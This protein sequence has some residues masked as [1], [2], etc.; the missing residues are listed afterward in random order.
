MNNKLTIGQLSKKVDLPTK[1]IRFYEESG[2]IGK[3]QRS[4]NGYRVYE[5]STIKELQLLK[6]ARD[7]GLPISEI[8]RLMIGCKEGK[9]CHHSQQYI[10]SGID[11]YMTVLDEKISHLATL[12]QKLSDLRHQLPLQK[13]QKDAYCCNILH[14]LS[15]DEKG[16]EIK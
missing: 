9:S 6:Y 5:S 2:V 1:T 7:L 10:E 14:Q 8:K 15:G 16:G 4:D 12:K 3:A 13:C 11:N